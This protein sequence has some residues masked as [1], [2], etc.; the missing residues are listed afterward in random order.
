MTIDRKLLLEDARALV[1]EVIELRRRLHRRPE[2]GLLLPQTQAAVV[3]ALAQLDVQIVTGQKLSSVIAVL[4]GY[5][6][7]PTVLLR[8]DMDALKMR[9]V[10]GVDF[11][12]E[13]DGAM[14]ACGHDC[15]T[16]MLIGAAKILA[17]HREQFAGRVIF[18]FQPGEE[19]FAG[20]KLMIEEG[21][22]DRYGVPDAAFAIH[23]SPTEPCG[24]VFTRPGAAMAGAGNFLITVIGRGGHPAMPHYAV[25]PIPIAA[26]IVIALQTYVTRRVKAFEPAVL[27]VTAIQAGNPELGAIPERAALAGTIRAVS[28]P[29]RQQLFGALKDLAG[30]IAAAHGA[31][32]Q[33]GLEAGYPPVVNDEHIVDVIAA[34][35]RDLFGAAKFH[36]APTPIMPSED[37]AYIL[38]R[39]PG[40]IAFLGARPPGDGPV[41]HV[42]SPRLVLNE[43]AMAVGMALHAGVAMD[44]IAGLTG[45]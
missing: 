36:L 2:I 30:N 17:R 34:V 21:L 5:A 32:A 28:E 14:H 20:A 4:E 27:T 1:G 11:A 41:A 9:E 38:Q 19:G 25:D 40:A 18:A 12:S 13:I 39:V 29:T 22:L 43:D 6:P 16:A 35:S 23:M 15:H 31:Q 3:Q 8:A 24:A 45:S 7:G 44:L 33:V 42:H 37:F 26:E 10:S